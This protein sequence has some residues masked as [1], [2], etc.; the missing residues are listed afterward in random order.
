MLLVKSSVKPGVHTHIH[1]YNQ[2]LP[3]LNGNIWRQWFSCVSDTLFL[4]AICHPGKCS[5]RPSWTAFA[6]GSAALFRFFYCLQLLLTS[7]IESYPEI[8]HGSWNQ[9]FLIFLGVMG[10]F[11]NIMKAVD[12]ILEKCTWT[13]IHKILHTIYFIALEIDFLHTEYKTIFTKNYISLNL[14]FSCKHQWPLLEENLSLPP[15][16]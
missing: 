1:W 11:G 6:L 9:W 16:D 2:F 3:H 10:P 15:E 13:Y 8:V 12:P 4:Y 14:V 7:E 5:F